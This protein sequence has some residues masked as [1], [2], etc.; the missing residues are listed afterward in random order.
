MSSLIWSSLLLIAFVSGGIGAIVMIR[1]RWHK[2][3]DDR[4]EWERR[5]V[6]YRNLRDKGVLNEEEYRKIRALFDPHVRLNTQFG[7]LSSSFGVRLK[8]KGTKETPVSDPQEKP[9]ESSDDCSK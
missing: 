1:S 8:G 2:A 4:A 5:L 6:E 7:G 9:L 3:S